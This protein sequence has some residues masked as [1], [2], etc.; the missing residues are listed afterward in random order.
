MLSNLLSIQHPIYMICL[1]SLYP[2]R[3]SINPYKEP[4]VNDPPTHESLPSRYKTIVMERSMSLMTEC[5]MSSS[6][7]EMEESIDT[8]GGHQE[9]FTTAAGE[10]GIMQTDTANGINNSNEEYEM[11]HLDNDCDE[12]KNGHFIQ[13]RTMLVRFEGYDDDDNE[14][15]DSQ[16]L[17]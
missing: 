15:C 12:N 16:S 17:I 4:C 1:T 11:F 5:S 9:E 6:E 10:N 3:D 8:N 13:A 14:S 7:E 2:D